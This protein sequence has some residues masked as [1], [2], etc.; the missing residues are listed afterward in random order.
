[1]NS[2]WLVLIALV[3]KLVLFLCAGGALLVVA[4]IGVLLGVPVYGII[5]EVGH[6]CVTGALDVTVTQM[7]VVINVNSIRKLVLRPVGQNAFR[8]QIAQAIT[9]LGLFGTLITH[10]VA[11]AN[12]II[13]VLPVAPLVVV[14]APVMIRVVVVTVRMMPN[15][16]VMPGFRQLGTVVLGKN[17]GR[18]RNIE[19]IIVRAI[20]PVL[21][22]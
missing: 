9:V 4:I 19:I 11:I 21:I 18:L 8:I 14:M 6:I 2:V 3:I 13:V 17:Q 12:V 16:Q 15:A 1:L 20:V 22:M 7:P 10:V 5:M